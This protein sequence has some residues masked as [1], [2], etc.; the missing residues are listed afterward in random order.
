MNLSLI[1]LNCIL[2]LLVTLGIAGCQQAD[3]P[4]ESSKSSAPVV[5]ESP[6]A[7]TQSLFSGDSIELWELTEF[8]GE[9]DVRV[10][11]GCI[12]MDAGDP[13]TAIN[14]PESFPLP[15]S[16]YEVEFEAMKVEG[17]DFFATLT[18]PVDKSFCSL[19]VGGWAG[20]VVGLSSIDRMDASEN[21]TR[22]L[23][24]F[25]RNQWY[26][27]RVRVTAEAIEAWIDDEQFVDQPIEGKEFSLRSE[28]IP[29][30][31]LGIANFYTISKIR[32]VELRWLKDG[33]NSAS[34]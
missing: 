1:R 25:E 28:M 34:P 14:L 9:G 10:E 22:R 20:T 17:T 4:V 11:D 30:R 29:C 24:K 5:S 7:K 8:G 15:T 21:E 26:T 16:E 3:K 32:N 27:I 23:K 31:P 33:A 19:V 18:F 12:V 6:F 2:C 13:I